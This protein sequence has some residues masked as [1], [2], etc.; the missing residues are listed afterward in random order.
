MQI[1][2]IKYYQFSYDAVPLITMFQLYTASLH[3]FSGN[4]VSS[5]LLVQI[6]TRK[7]HDINP[8]LHTI[9]FAGTPR[10]LCAHG[11]GNEPN[12]WSAVTVTV[13]TRWR[14]NNPLQLWPLIPIT[15][16]SLPTAKKHFDR[17]E[18]CLQ[19]ITWL[20]SF[21]IALNSRWTA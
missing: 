1:I 6:V 13:G 2:L 12:G 8:E 7:I 4:K 15:I 9:N 3:H 17:A 21:C 11:M 10:T 18:H 14:P 20:M 16:A 19:E 5:K